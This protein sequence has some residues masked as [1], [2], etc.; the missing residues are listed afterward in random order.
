MMKFMLAG[1]ACMLA[2]GCV[3]DAPL[4]DY[5]DAGPSIA[6]FAVGVGLTL[7]I[8]VVGGILFGMDK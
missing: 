5:T 1:V 3:V 4:L 8:A 6:E 7:T 2:M